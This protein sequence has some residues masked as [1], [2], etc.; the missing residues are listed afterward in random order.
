MVVLTT[1]FVTCAKFRCRSSLAAANLLLVSAAS[2]SRA[3]AP[4]RGLLLQHRHRNKSYLISLNNRIGKVS[5]CSIA[6]AAT[7]ASEAAADKGLPLG[8]DETMVDE[9]ASQSK[10]LQ[11]FVKIPSFG[12]AWIF[13]SKDE[14]TSKAMVSIGQSDLLANKRRKFLLNSHISKT[15]S[16]SVHFQWSPFPTEISGVSAVIPSPS[17]EKLLLVRSSEDD[18]PT[19]LEIWGPC[20]L[21]N[22]IHIAK[23][24]HGSLYTDEWFEGI[25]W[26]QEETFIAY[27]AEEPP[28]LKPVFNDHGFQKEGS[29][30]KDC[31]SWKGQ[32]D[33]EETWGET[34]SKKRIPAL[35]VVNISSG[36]VRPVKGIPRSLSVGQVIWAPS[37]S[38]GLVF[39][40]WSSENGFQATPRKLGV[41]YCYNRPCALYA[42]PDPFREE[43]G[44]PSPEGYKGETTSM[45]KLTSDLS[46]AFFPRFR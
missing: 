20:Q 17:G 33:W 31:K 39:V 42:A 12:K 43:A 11:E 46:S 37:S 35:F 22:E 34:Y 44:K 45:I 18:S 24:V 29:S 15:A 16:K 30:E 2:P 9:Y 4:P 3:R 23:S 10:L 36:E 32:G 25:S 41:K 26:N 5:L 13:N 7:Q 6:M 38:Y 19:K 1:A 40:A 21:E 28:Q 8:M 27:V 14:N